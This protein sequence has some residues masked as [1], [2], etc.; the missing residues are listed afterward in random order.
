MRVSDERILCLVGDFRRNCVDILGQFESKLYFDGRPTFCR[1]QT[2][3]LT[4]SRLFI[5]IPPVLAL[6]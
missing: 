6:S 1:L 3:K 2:A 5:K 4:I